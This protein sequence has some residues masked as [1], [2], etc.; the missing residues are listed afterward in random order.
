M[1]QAQTKDSPQIGQVVA[2]VTVS[3][4]V[5][6]DQESRVSQNFDLDYDGTV[7]W[8]I[9]LNPPWVGNVFFTVMRDKSGKK[10]QPRLPN[11]S[12]GSQTLG[13][14][15]GSGGNLYIGRLQMLAP[16]QTKTTYDDIYVFD[17]IGVD[18]FLIE[19]VAV[20]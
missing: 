18:S 8:R 19:A 10:D 2:T 17:A 11:V 6:Q 20:S 5:A 14:M 4:S 16:D 1:L 3:R 12:D 7:E 9:E 15:D 13:Q